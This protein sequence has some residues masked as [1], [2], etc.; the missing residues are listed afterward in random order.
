MRDW[1]RIQR[2]LDQTLPKGRED[3]DVH[4]VRH[5]APGLA[6]EASIL[7]HIADALRRDQPA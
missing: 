1:K 6:D 5:P 7:E 4:R 2:E 3:P